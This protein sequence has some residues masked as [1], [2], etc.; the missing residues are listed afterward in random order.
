[1]KGTK[2]RRII[3]IVLSIIL[4]LV[5]V[6]VV[7]GTAYLEK[8]LSLIQRE[9]DNS[10]ISSEEYQEFIEQQPEENYTG[11]TGDPNDVQWE[12]NETPVEAQEHIINVMLVGQDR[13]PGQGRQRSD[14][15]ILCTLNLATKELTM[16]SFM[17]DMYVPIPGFKDNKMNASY[18]FGGM[19]LLDKVM[20]ESFRVHV[21]GYIEVDFSGFKNVI[22]LIGGV[23]IKLTE[24]EANHLTARGYSNI[25]AGKNLLNGAAAL[26]YARNRSIGHSD[27]TRTQRQRNVMT[28]VFEKCKN[29]SLSQ[30]TN[31]LEEA[32]PMVTTDMTNRQMM[33]Y[34]AKVV[35]MLPGLKLNS[36]RIPADGTYKSVYYSHAGS[37]LVPDLEANRKLLE[38]AMAKPE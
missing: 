35:P 12:T 3:L 10:I 28:A 20:E 30:L 22:D 7:A 27:F 36:Q 24:A 18:A 13:L 14:S 6:A 1:M 16:T 5:I 34:L 25:T 8:L 21:D 31:L 11:E 2:V 4:V 26:T 23:E 37:T 19:K 15:M 17:R 33:S 32:L 29:M 9:P 38:K